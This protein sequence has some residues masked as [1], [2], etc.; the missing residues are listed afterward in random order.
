VLVPFLERLFMKSLTGCSSGR[1]D[2]SE[3]F[4]DSMSLSLYGLVVV[5]ISNFSPSCTGETPVVVVA[6]C[7]FY[8]TLLDAPCIVF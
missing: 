1:N 7:T 5:E 4:I 3:F 6:S 2:P 8:F